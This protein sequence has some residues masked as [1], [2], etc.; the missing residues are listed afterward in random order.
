LTK[1]S[2]GPMEVGQKFFQLQQVKKK[3]GRGK[4]QCSRK[5][6]EPEESSNSQNPNKNSIVLILKQLYI[7]TQKEDGKKRG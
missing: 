2:P 6:D 3:K 7:E 1:K 4:R 5:E